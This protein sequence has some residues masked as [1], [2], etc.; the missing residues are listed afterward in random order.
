M[1]RIFKA[2]YSKLRTVK[3]RNGNITYDVKN[4]KKTPR[5]EPVLDGDGKPVLAE[6]RKWYIEYK[7]ADGIVRRVAGFRDKKA[8]EQRAAQLEREAAQRETGLIDRHA[9][10]RQ[11]PLEAH[12]IE[13]EEALNAKGN[14]EKHAAEQSKRARQVFNACKF[15]FWQ[16]ISASKV[17]VH[18]ADMRKGT[19][20]K[21]GVGARTSNSYLQACKQFGNWMVRD[22]R[23]ASN[24]LSHL[25]RCKA[26]EKR[27]RRRALTVE[28]CR[29]LIGATE[30]A[31]DNYGMTGAE[32]AMMYRVALG[33]GFRVAEIRSLTL[34]SFSLAGKYPTIT[35][36][37][38]YSK[39]RTRREQPIAGKLADDLEIF[40]ASR[41]PEAPVFKPNADKTADMLRDDLA[42]A[43]IP[44]EDSAGNRVDFHALRHTYITLGAQAGIAP[45]VLMDLARHS[46]INLTMKVYSHTVVADR[47]R[48]L[49]AIPDITG[50]GGQEAEVLR[51]TGTCD[52]TPDTASSPIFDDK[53]NDKRVSEGFRESTKKPACIAGF[54]NTPRRARTCDPLIKSLRVFLLTHV[55]NCCLLSQKACF[56]GDLALCVR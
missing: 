35:V 22:D 39:N 43:N 27:V 2:T 24:P 48:A 50:D 9:E 7:D 29:R 15:R 4:G 26:A 8:T 18:L 12:L 31:E 56:I 11:R 16:D 37:A 52:D 5:R 38:A 28:E 53:Q 34:Q 55:D 25:Q 47:A 30:E 33:T 42:K 49:E 23:A 20:E 21:K 46:D 44:S 13:W 6:S 51:A 17:Q 36:E 40:L 45:K 3:D 41:V 32:R 1:A 54:C 14:T 19:E 10:H